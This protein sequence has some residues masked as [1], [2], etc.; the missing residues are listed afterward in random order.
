MIFFFAGRASSVTATQDGH[1]RVDALCAHDKSLPLHI[2]AKN[3]K[4][5]ASKHGNNIT[6]ILDLCLH[7]RAAE[8]TARSGPDPHAADVTA[9]TQLDDLWNTDSHVVLA[10]E[11]GPNFGLF[12]QSLIPA[13]VTAVKE[14]WTY[15]EL[16]ENLIST[17]GS[18]R[19]QYC[20]GV[21]KERVVFTTNPRA[22]WTDNHE[23]PDGSRYHSWK[24]AR[25]LTVVVD[26]DNVK[27]EAQKLAIA[28]TAQIQN[29]VHWEE[30]YFESHSVKQEDGSF[31]DEI[32]KPGARVISHK[33]QITFRLYSKTPSSDRIDYWLYITQHSAHLSDEVLRSL[34]PNAHG[35][36]TISRWD[37]GHLRGLG[38]ISIFPGGFCQVRWP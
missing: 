13:L 32:N 6:V 1:R 31:R 38:P 37:P 3:L 9:N 8:T 26:N 7:D 24:T 28:A 12:T 23:Q 18:T 4:K 30:I 16:I 20:S 22:T 29:S 2:L 36:A 35:L 19:V 11:E 34:L 25:S 5:L 15:S 21:H 14:E 27:S 33:Y 17:V 10:A